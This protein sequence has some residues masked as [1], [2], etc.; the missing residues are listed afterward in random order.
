MLARVFI[1]SLIMVVAGSSGSSGQQQTRTTAPVVEVQEFPVVFQK[2]V[3]A[4]KTGVGQ[5]FKPNCPWLP[6]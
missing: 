6:C 2:S 3:T 5:Q 1:A 4:G